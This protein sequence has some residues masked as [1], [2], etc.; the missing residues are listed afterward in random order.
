MIEHAGNAEYSLVTRSSDGKMLFLADR[1]SKMKQGTKLGSRI[2]EVHS[3]SSLFTGDAGHAAGYQDFRP[4]NSVYGNLGLKL[5]QALRL[6]L[7]DGLILAASFVDVPQ[8][9]LGQWVFRLKPAMVDALTTLGWFEQSEFDAAS[10][11]ALVTKVAREGRVVLALRRHRYREQSLRRTKLRETLKQGRRLICEV[12]GCG[13]DFAAKYGMLGR[14][15]A[16]VHHKKPVSSSDKT[17]ETRLSD[18][19]IVCSNCH[20]MI[21][22]DGGLRTLQEVGRSIRNAA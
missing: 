16:E 14:T 20:R 19:A 4:A 11:D 6:P 22:R 5:R 13:F 21:H 12:P 2:A 9:N 10:A 15:F 7:N 18:L 8:K 1:L 3:G 17:R